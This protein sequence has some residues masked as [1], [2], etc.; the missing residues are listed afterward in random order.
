MYFIVLCL[1]VDVIIFGESF[2]IQFLWKSHPPNTQYPIMKTTPGVYDI[3]GDGLV[4]FSIRGKD[5][6]GL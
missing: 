6:K 3:L 2:E 1:G 4:L 5:M